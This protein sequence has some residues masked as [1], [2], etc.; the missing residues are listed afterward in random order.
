MI[1]TKGN[2]HADTLICRDSRTL[3]VTAEDSCT[4]AAVTV[5]VSSLLSIQRREDKRL[6][7]TARHFY[8]HNT[9]Y[10]NTDKSANI[11]AIQRKMAE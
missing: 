3:Q 6:T 10:H 8:N 5:T 9:T 4:E 2:G 1:Q 7:T 11:S